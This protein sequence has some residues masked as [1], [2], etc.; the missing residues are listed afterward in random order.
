MISVAKDPD[1]DPRVTLRI[2]SW[3]IWA[4]SNWQAVATFARKHQANVL[5]LQE[6]DRRW[7][8]RTRMKDVPHEIALLLDYHHRF[9]PSISVRG[10]GGEREYG[11]AIISRF[12]ITASSGIALPRSESW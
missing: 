1:T 10:V 7:G 8:D 12:P 9:H 11:N 2:L 5:A 3:N 6:V 4:R